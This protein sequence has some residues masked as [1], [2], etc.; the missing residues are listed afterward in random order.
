MQIARS[1]PYSQSQF[2]DPGG[3]PKTTAS[4]STQKH[5]KMEQH[6]CCS[7]EKEARLGKWLELNLSPHPT[8]APSP[9]PASPEAGPLPFPLPFPGVVAAWYSRRVFLAHLHL[10]KSLLTSLYLSVAFVGGRE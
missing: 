5:L 8:H 6:L 4:H 9:L 3:E 2:K 1:H 10:E 7:R